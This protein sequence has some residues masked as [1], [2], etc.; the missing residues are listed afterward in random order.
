MSNE[1]PNQN[2]RPA[3]GYVQEPAR[4]TGW[5]AMLVVA[6]LA[7]GFS[8]S[9]VEYERVWGQGQQQR[10]ELLETA[11]SEAAGQLEDL[12]KILADPQTRL[13]RLTAMD[14]SPITNAMIVWNSSRQKGYF[15]CDQLRM[16]DA[17]MTYE[18]WTR[19]GSDEP[20]RIAGIQPK[21][22]QSVYPFRATGAQSRDRLEISAG[23]PSAQN[24]PILTG[25]FD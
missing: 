25:E 5:G 9:A 15:L 1:T 24:A 11:D 8:A 22:G 10:A 7:L 13:I 6:C 18:V 20:I 16:L 23:A 4:G 3:L 21:A 17:G 12:G 14:A 2:D 19:R